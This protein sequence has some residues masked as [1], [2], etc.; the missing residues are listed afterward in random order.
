MVSSDWQSQI[1]ERKKNGSPNLGDS[2]LQWLTSSNLQFQ[3][4]VGVGGG[5]NGMGGQTDNL[6]INKQ[7]EGSK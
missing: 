4:I 1:F 5:L 3:V 6:N 2:L 7:V